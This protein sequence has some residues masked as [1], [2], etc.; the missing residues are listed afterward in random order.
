MRQEGFDILQIKFIECATTEKSKMSQNLKEK[1]QQQRDN[2]MSRIFSMNTKELVEVIDDPTMF[3]AP[4]KE[5]E[6]ISTCKDAFFVIYAC[7][8]PAERQALTS[9]IIES[10]KT[11]A[12][13]IGIDNPTATVNEVT[14]K[15]ANSVE[16]ARR[17][18]ETVLHDEEELAKI[19]AF[20]DDRLA[21][22]NRLRNEGWTREEMLLYAQCVRTMGS[23]LLRAN[24]S[25]GLNTTELGHSD[26]WHGQLNRE[27]QIFQ[28]RGNFDSYDSAETFM[29]SASPDDFNRT[30]VLS[31]MSE[32]KKSEILGSVLRLSLLEVPLC[33]RRSVSVQRAEYQIAQYLQLK[34]EGEEEG[35]GEGI[36]ERA[37]NELESLSNNESTKKSFFQRLFSKNDDWTRHELAVLL[38]CIHH[39][40][41]VDG[42]VDSNEM[43]L[44]KIEMRKAE[45]LGD[46][47]SEA[48]LANF[49]DVSKNISQEEIE[50]CLSKLSDTKKRIF[51]EALMN[52]AQVDGRMT[53]HEDM[54]IKI[55]SDYMS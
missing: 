8:S 29:V 22:L 27:I 21:D 26:N 13:K 23:A 40:L 55:F 28:H 36:L 12:E 53:A 2:E 11:L 4:V 47:K 19:A 3:F 9:Y 14:S 32:L 49:F 41:M 18:G 30:D 44:M 10:D 33:G 1:E 50:L 37:E 42:E 48:E 52:M 46:F 5:I 38:K 17:R 51:K 16:E 25:L 34:S 24:P 45:V 39:I 7:L 43:V 15:K 31:S 6:S 35:E 54:A 20:A